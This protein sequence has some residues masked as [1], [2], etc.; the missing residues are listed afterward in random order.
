MYASK[1]EPGL[2]LGDESSLNGGGVICERCGATR[3]TYPRACTADSDHRCPA[4]EAIER[5]RGGLLRL[6]EDTR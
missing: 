2:D 4:F 5:A 1:A 3:E 6:P